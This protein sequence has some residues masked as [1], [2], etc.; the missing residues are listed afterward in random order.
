M[1]DGRNS[2]KIKCR[3]LEKCTIF[4]NFKRDFVW[5]I[6]FSC[7]FSTGSSAQNGRQFD[8]PLAATITCTGDILM[9]WPYGLVGEIGVF[10]SCGH[11]MIE[12][13]SWTYHYVDLKWYELVWDDMN[14]Y[15]TVDGNQ[16]SGETHQL[17]L[18]VS[19]F[20]LLTQGFFYIQSGE[21]PDFLPFF[22]YE[23]IWTSMTSNSWRV[24]ATTA[25]TEFGWE[26]IVSRCR[27]DQP[28]TQKKDGF[29]V[30]LR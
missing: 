30:H 9:F 14:W 18:V 1:L 4:H 28:K 12:D 16:K 25:L 19:L 15:E 11:P 21:S 26:T 20:P 3:L 29:L 24:T 13:D 27:E 6:Q 7:F 8:S 5:Q 10:G 23:M 2:E 17:R 22:L